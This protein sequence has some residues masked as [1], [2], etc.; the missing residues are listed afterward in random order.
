MA[1]KVLLKLKKILIAST[2][3]LFF[4]SGFSQNYPSFGSEIKV[5][6]TGLTFDAMEPFIAANGNL[7]LFNSLNSGGNTNLYYATKVNDSTFN[8]VGLLGGVYDSSPNHLDAVASLDSLSNFYWVSLRGYPGSFE[9]LHR[10]IYT[11]GNVTNI[12]RVYGNFNI[13]GFNFPFGWLIM[14][15]AINYQGDLLYY[16]NAL[17]DFNNTTCAGLPCQAKLGIAQKLND[18]TFNKI[19][20]MDAILSQVNDTN[21]L[22]YA[23][24]V[25]K[26]GLELYYT[27][28]LKGSLNTEICVSVRNSVSSTFSLPSIIHSNIGFA[29]EG[30]TLTN[31]NQKIYYHQK[32]NSGKY[33]IYLRYN[34]TT[35]KVSDLSLK[36]TIKVHPNPTNG[37]LRITL[38][39][40]QEVL[41]LSLFSIYG[42][43]IQQLSTANSNSIPFEF[44]APSGCYLLKISN[45][46]QEETVL[47][48]IKE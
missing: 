8:Y 4:L 23:P 19:P 39:N 13:Y 42:K 41:K 43:L 34:N 14:D 48:I 38:S 45:A 26:D 28:L 22:V 9:N 31:N 20:N 47:K 3:I 10:G 32:D 18:S 21:Y 17:F 30:P 15:A 16:A 37:K 36:T 35:T 44:E 46:K 6:L 25:S 27:R 24:Q 12:S 40:R 29:P 7:L 1:N 5:T 2:C 11:S 33:G